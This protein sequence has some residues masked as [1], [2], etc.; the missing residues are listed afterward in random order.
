MATD[1]ETGP[2]TANDDERAALDTIL[3]RFLTDQKAPGPKLV[4]PRGEEIALPESLFQ[5]LRQLAYHLAQG[6]AVSVVPLNKELTTQQAADILNVSRPFLIKLLDRGE[7]P[8]SKTGS[9]RRIRFSD[10]MAYKRRRDAERQRVLAR[11]T[12][13]S[14]EM[15]LY[16]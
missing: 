8:F 9:H 12:R 5:V 15:G 14:Q 16:E 3:Q 1:L 10:L 13:M 4:G 6:Q 2:V 7:V 11:L